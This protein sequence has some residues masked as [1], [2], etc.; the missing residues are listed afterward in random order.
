MSKGY[1][2]SQYEQTIFF[3]QSN[4]NGNLR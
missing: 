3:I 2:P 1:S 4:G